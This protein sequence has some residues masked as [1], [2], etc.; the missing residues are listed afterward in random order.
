MRSGPEFA[1]NLALAAVASVHSGPSRDEV[2]YPGI[3]P[4]GRI[5]LKPVHGLILQRL[6]ACSG[7]VM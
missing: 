2:L 5:E 3:F 6:A 1:F 4:F 7:V